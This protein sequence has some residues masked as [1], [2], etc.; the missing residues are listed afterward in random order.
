MWYVC[1]FVC[2]TLPFLSSLLLASWMPFVRL[3]SSERRAQS[4]WLHWKVPQQL[5]AESCR[6][7]S[8]GGGPQVHHFSSQLAHHVF[9]TN[10]TFVVTRADYALSAGAGQLTFPSQ[11]PYQDWGSMSPQC[12]QWHCIVDAHV[13]LL[14]AFTV[15]TCSEV[16]MVQDVHARTEKVQSQIHIISFFTTADVLGKPSWRNILQ[17][18]I[19]HAVAWRTTDIQ[20]TQQQ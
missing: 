7:T 12:E 19:Q 6:N 1:V 13:V 5:S 17:N 16:C 11:K 4:Y 18:K 2:Y 9:N 15:T 8:N 10:A 3:W 20:R 14:T